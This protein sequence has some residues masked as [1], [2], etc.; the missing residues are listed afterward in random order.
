MGNSGTSPTANLPYPGGASTSSI[1]GFPTH[2]TPIYPNPN[3]QQLYY[4]TMAYGTNIPP[5]PTGTDVP[6]GPIP[7]IFFPRTPAYVTPNLRVEGEVNDGVRDQIARTLKEFGFTSKGRARSYQKTYPE[8]FDVIP[9]SRG[10]WV[11]DLAKFMGDDAK[12]TYEHIGQF[13]A[14]VNDVGITNMH[15]IRM[16]PLSRTGAAFNWFTS[17]PPNSI[18]S[19]ASL[20]QKFHD[21]FYKGEVEL[22]LSDLTSLRQKYTKTISDYLRRFWE[23]RNWCYNL[24]IAEKDLADLALADL[25]SYLK[26]KLD[27][28]EFSNT[29]QLLQRALPYENHA[30]SS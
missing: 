26:D 6:H 11:S 19:L 27:G 18:E 14:Q 8:Y 17:L 22:R 23:V 7:A 16:F 2:T 10:F 30:K 5:P 25:T 20:E 1:T 13:L 9:Y 21:Y 12:T 29:N 24:T 15:K 4:E 28:Q 3:F